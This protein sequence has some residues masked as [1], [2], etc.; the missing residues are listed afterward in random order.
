MNDETLRELSENNVQ[1]RN[2]VQQFIEKLNT[3]EQ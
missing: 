3:E 2:I 1:L